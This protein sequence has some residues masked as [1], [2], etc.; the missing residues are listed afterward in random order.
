[1]PAQRVGSHRFS[2]G[3]PRSNRPP[4]S[5]RGQP[6]VYAQRTDLLPPLSARSRNH[7]R[8]RKGKNPGGD[9][10]SKPSI[11]TVDDDPVVSA[12]VA[13]DLRGRYGADYRIVRATSGAQALDVL[14][15]MALR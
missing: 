7:W 2:G 1:M 13:R 3:W 8:P 11:L 10:V 4:R 6:C 9:K 5:R 15:R 14:A 12:A